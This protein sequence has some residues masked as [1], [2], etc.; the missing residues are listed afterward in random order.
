M[1]SNWLTDIVH[2]HYT[3]ILNSLVLDSGRQHNHTKLKENKVLKVN[4]Y[5]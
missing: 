4:Y 3:H 1:C 2:T 5:V